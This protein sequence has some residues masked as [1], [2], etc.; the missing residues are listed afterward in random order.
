MRLNNSLTKKVESLE[1]QNAK[2]QDELAEK[3][4]EI[5]RLKQINERLTEDVR[6]HYEVMKDVEFAQ[7]TFNKGIE[8]IAKLKEQYEQAIF[9]AKEVKGKY[10]K[11]FNK[12]L[13]RIK[14][15]N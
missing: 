5:Q 4:K 10:K 12:Q 9:D 14:R 7:N 15:Q 11:K 1:R 3:D 2:L 8:D 13:K 6:A